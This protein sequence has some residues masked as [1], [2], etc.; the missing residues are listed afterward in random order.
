[1]ATPP[2]FSPSRKPLALAAS[3]TFSIRPRTREA[4]SAF[5]VQIGFRTASM[6][7]MAMV[8]AGLARKGAAQV[9]LSPLGY[10]R[11]PGEGSIPVPLPPPAS[12]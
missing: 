10:D 1:M 7:S 8:S 3:K 4:V 12:H 5:V 2:G 11:V 9:R 6:S